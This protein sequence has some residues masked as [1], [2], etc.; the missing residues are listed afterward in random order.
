[1]A[2]NL[3][4]V[5]DEGF[6]RLTKLAEKRAEILRQAKNISSTS[7]SPTFQAAEEKFRK[8]KEDYNTEIVEHIA[9]LQ[10]DL[11]KTLDQMVANGNQYLSNLKTQLDF[12]IQKVVAQQDEAQQAVLY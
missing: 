8:R 1:M 7:G 9:Y 12:S 11:R 2:K 4:E 5:V 6:T 3:K 10:N